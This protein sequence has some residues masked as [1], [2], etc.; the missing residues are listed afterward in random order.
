MGEYLVLIDG[1]ILCSKCGHPY[2]QVEQDPIDYALVIHQPTLELGPL[3]GEEDSPFVFFAACCPNCKTCF[4]RS[5]M[6]KGRRPPR[7]IELKG[8]YQDT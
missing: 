3:F 2:C 8:P 5:V 4:Y 1:M 7:D 6:E